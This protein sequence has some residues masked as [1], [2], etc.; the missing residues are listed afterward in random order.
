MLRI[1]AALLALGLALP[2][3]ADDGIDIGM[4]AREIRDGKIAVGKTYSTTLE[5]DSR[6]H[7]L[8]GDALGLG[9]KSCHTGSA[10]QADFI[11]LRKGEIMPREARG[12]V[13]RAVCLGCHQTGGP[14]T[15]WYVGRSGR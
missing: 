14:A 2:V 9:C 5:D 4:A 11:F 12:Q 1:F 10:Y 7:N 6:F 3:L 13:D 8:H 15:A